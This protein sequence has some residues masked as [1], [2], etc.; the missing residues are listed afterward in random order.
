MAHE[1]VFEAAVVAVPHVQWQERPIACKE[2]KHVTKE[3]R[4]DF[5]RPQFANW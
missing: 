1:A 3:E 5:L 2:G 4:Y